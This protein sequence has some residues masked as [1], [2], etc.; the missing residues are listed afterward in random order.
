MGGAG[1][2][3]STSPARGGHRQVA[4][5][6]CFGAAGIFKGKLTPDQTLAALSPDFS[7]TFEEFR[8]VCPEMRDG[9]SAPRHVNVI[10]VKMYRG[11]DAR[12][13]CVVIVVKD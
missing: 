4:M 10:G 3:P 2:R 5:G 6:W 12:L 1:S 11:Q 8:K 7:P 13:G 9:A